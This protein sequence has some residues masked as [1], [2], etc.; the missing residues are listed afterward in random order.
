MKKRDLSLITFIKENVGVELSRT[1]EAYIR[2]PSRLQNANKNT[3]RRIIL[4]YRPIYQKYNHILDGS[5][6]LIKIVSF[7]FDLTMKIRNNAELIDLLN[8]P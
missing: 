8:Q 6:E 4:E 7:G 2:E 5:E 1:L 3:L